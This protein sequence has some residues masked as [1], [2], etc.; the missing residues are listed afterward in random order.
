MAKYQVSVLEYKEPYESIKNL[1]DLINGL[2]N[3]P[4]NSKIFIKPNVVYWNRHCDFPKWG[5][6]TTSRVVEDVVKILVE[7]GFSNI[8]IGEGIITEEKDDE[9]TVKDAFQ[10]LGYYTLRERFGVKV[11]NTFDRPFERIY[12]TEEVSAK[13]NAD[14]IH[15]DFLVNLPVL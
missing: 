2:D 15:S 9:E 11:L 13:M 12:L 1:I 7:K 5:M 4:K 10:S 3:V 6:I 8:S 14:M